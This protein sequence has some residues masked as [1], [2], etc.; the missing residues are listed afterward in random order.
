M[1]KTN[2]LICGACEAKGQKQVLG[3]IA[4]TGEL[5]IMRF[6]NG[7]TN[8]FSDAFTVRCGSCGEIVYQRMGT[9]I[10][11]GTLVL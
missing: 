5:S 9:A 8:I 4:P 6:H 10:M 1:K 11:H 7:F 2:L 3:E